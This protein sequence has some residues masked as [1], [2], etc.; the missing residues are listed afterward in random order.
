MAVESSPGPLRVLPNLAL[1]FLSRRTLRI[2]SLPC[3]CWP[4]GESQRKWLRRKKQAVLLTPSPGEQGRASEN[5]VYKRLGKARRRL[6]QESGAWVGS[7]EGV[8]WEVPIV[9]Q[10][11]Q[12]A[13]PVKLASREVLM[14]SGLGVT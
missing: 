7:A 12:N 9:A 1:G 6:V 11:K 14:R 2:A 3:G 13:L 4:E 10:G 5:K 8:S